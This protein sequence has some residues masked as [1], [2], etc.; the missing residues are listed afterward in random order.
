[1]IILK[2]EGGWSAAFS[3]LSGLPN[4]LIFGGRVG[5]KLPAFSGGSI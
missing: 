5:N 3:S 4:R 1:M 2:H